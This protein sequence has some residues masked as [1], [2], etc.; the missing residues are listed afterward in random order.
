MFGGIGACEQTVDVRGGPRA[1]AA[2]A[3]TQPGD[4]QVIVASRLG[5]GLVMRPGMPNFSA[6]L[7]TNRELGALLQRMWTLLRRR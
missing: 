4:R 3:A 1:V 5:S 6:E 7:R 2:A